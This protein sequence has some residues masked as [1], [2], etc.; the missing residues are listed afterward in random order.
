MPIKD[1]PHLQKKLQLIDSNRLTRLREARDYKSLKKTVEIWA[2]ENLHPTILNE[3]QREA[4]YLMADF[5]HNFSNQYIIKR[6]NIEP[7]TFYK[8]RND[9]VFL[10]EL[11][12]EISRRKTFIRIHAWRNVHRAV[13]RGDMKATWNYLKMV[14][15]L[16]EHVE[17]V[18]RTGEQEMDD[19]Q[20]NQEIGRLNERLLAAHTPS[21]N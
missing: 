19:E 14:G 10:R 18:D 2:E 16:K 8:W 6:L 3:V 17:V 1:M 15:D 13:S 9:P 4:V 12:K 21:T 5:V 11:D 7:T 20:L